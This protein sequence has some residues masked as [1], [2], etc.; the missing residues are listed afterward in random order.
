[1][2]SRSAYNHLEL[3]SYRT[4][5][6]VFKPSGTNPVD[7]IQLNKSRRILVNCV[8]VP[9]FKN[10]F[11]ISSKPGDLLLFNFSMHLEIQSILNV[12]ALERFESDDR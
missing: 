12:E 4:K 8:F 1:M 9:L 11:E 10:S 5:I 2:K 7:S 6:E 3:L